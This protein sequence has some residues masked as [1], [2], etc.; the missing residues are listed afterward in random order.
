MTAV[1]GT[2]KEAAKAPVASVVA[3]TPGTVAPA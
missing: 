2:A 1:A 3:V